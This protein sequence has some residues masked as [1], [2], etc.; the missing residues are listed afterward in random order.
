M[1]RT[2]LVLSFAALTVGCASIE[3][4]EP[5]ILP[6]FPGNTEIQ[7]R[8]VGD[9]PI[10]GDFDADDAYGHGY[11]SEDFVDVTINADG[12]FGWAMLGLYTSVDANG[13]ARLDD[14]MV[15]GCSGP[16]TLY[17]EFDEPADEAII[18]IE[19][20]VIEGEDF[21]DI[22]VVASFSGGQ[23]V[24]GTAVVPVTDGW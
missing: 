4:G 3:P 11:A 22:Q 1:F 21:L 13:D 5:D 8:M 19:P 6:V 18:D 17:A 10:V 14:G 16:D 23:E 20:I 2:A 15:I 24:T 9:L 7:G 12:D